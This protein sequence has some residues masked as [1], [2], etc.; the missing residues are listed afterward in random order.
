MKLPFTPDQFFH[1]FENYNAA[2]WPMQVLFIFVAVLCIGF[3]IRPNAWSDRLTGGV[4]AFF[5]IWMGAVYHWMHFASI[6]PAARFFGALFIFQGLLFVYAIVMKKQITFRFTR[7]LSGY[8]SLLLILYALLLYPLLGH[9]LGHRFP[10]SPTFGVPCPPTI[11][12]LGILLLATHK[13]PVWLVI[14][15]IGWCLVGTSAALSLGVKEDFGLMVAAVAFI[16]LQFVPAK[17]IGAVNVATTTK[18]GT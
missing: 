14:I 2:V 7:S 11:F 10:A 5:W 3:A 15:P 6:N 13:V 4:L 18:S 9:A 17:G 12:T 1:V 8:V 16:V